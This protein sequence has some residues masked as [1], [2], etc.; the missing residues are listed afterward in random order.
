[1]IAALIDHLWQSTLFA[2]GAGAL[3]LALRSNAARFRYG[4]WFAAS[5]KFLV[6][7]AALASAGR[8]VAAQLHPAAA[9]PAGLLL[10]RQVVEP[11]AAAPIAPMAAAGV[12]IVAPPAP[13]SLA[14]LI[15][16]AVWAVGAAC[17]LTLWAVRWRRVRA[18]L[19]ASSPLMLDR[20]IT[21][22]A[23][24]S[25]LEPGVVGVLRPVVMVPIGIEAHLSPAEWQ[26]VLAHE[27]CHLRRRDNLTAAFHMLVEALFWFHP[28]VWWIGGRL[29]A[30]RERACDEGVIT[31]G[32]EPRV[33]AEGLLKVCRFYLRSPLAC[34]AGVS[35]GNL[36]TRVARI[37][38]GAAGAR[39][40]VRKAALMSAAAGL[41][42]SA[43]LAAG[44]IAALP[45]AA[46]TA[47]LANAGPQGPAATVA[48][49]TASPQAGAAPA[50]QARTLA[51]TL[52]QSA[53]TLAAPGE[54]LADAVHIEPVAA[55]PLRLAALA[56]PETTPAP[57]GGGADAAPGPAAPSP[58][59]GCRLPAVA[60]FQVDAGSYVPLID[61][62]INGRKVK[63]IAAV[64]S[65]TVLFRSDAKALKVEE[66]NRSTG[67]TWPG[68]AT[69][70]GSGWIHDLE[71]DGMPRK[72]LSNY[73]VHEDFNIPVVD[74]G[75]GWPSNPGAMLGAQFWALADNDFDLAAHSISL[76]RPTGCAPR[77]ILPFNG[78]A[79][80][81]TPLLT[82]ATRAIEQRVTVVVDGVPLEALIDT[83]AGAT[84]MTRQGA[85]KLSQSW[86]LPG[87]EPQGPLFTGGRGQIPWAKARFK[88]FSIGEETIQNPRIVVADLYN[89]PQKTEY[90]WKYSSVAHPGGVAMPNRNTPDM[91]LGADFFHAH[92]VLISNSRRMMY[93]VYNGGPIFR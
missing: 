70:F 87:A 68:G 55:P 39:L 42:V 9:A 80:S 78:G 32:H 2:L 18:A 1:M 27:L 73:D 48:S 34:A 66:M 92:H 45:A 20:Q 61:G 76:V 77:D 26:A 46:R 16:A 37:M 57:V 35:G 67:F 25:L 13:Y 33:Y 58:A 22:R 50:P 59:A 62:E 6:P 53:Q 10:V 15:L 75:A 83:S 17:V 23:S 28:L 65:L 54:A 3:T 79:Y 56:A 85:S 41:A 64:S 24:A 63:F 82:G 69:Q 91:I 12:P 19:I 43:P 30:E 88:T 74:G 29:I 90:L 47:I 81:K 86:P 4:V 93:F 60:T 89:L 11:F 8:W 52:E 14:P 49:P 5:V 84:I 72:V 44:L 71:L 36:K 31:A 38:T 21:A 40:G 7:F 51:Q